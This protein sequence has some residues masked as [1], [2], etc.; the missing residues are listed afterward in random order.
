PTPDL[1]GQLLAEDRQ[2]F[3]IRRADMCRK[4][5]R[6]T[7]FTAA[8]SKPEQVGKFACAQPREPAAVIQ[9]A[10]GQAPIAIEAVP[11]EPGGLEPF[12]AHGLH[13][14]PEDRLHVSDFYEHG[15]SEA[16]RHCA[17]DMAGLRPPA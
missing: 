2:L 3:A 8:G 5:S 12:P 9:A 1:R 11:A 13:G 6:R 14:K 17:S 10:E 4:V 15:R 7:V 16:A